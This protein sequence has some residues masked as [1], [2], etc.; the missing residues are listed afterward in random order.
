[1]DHLDDFWHV[2]SPILWPEPPKYFSYSGLNEI[3]TCPR[4]WALSNATYGT[5]GTR[6]LYP[7]K[8]GLSALA[9]QVIHATLDDLV[10]A[11][12]A[13]GCQTAEDAVDVLRSQGGISSAIEQH[14]L[15]VVLSLEANPRMRPRAQELARA[16][17]RQTPE[18]REV[19]QG[20][21]GQV[22]FAQPTRLVA[23]GGGA[24]GTRGVLGHGLH[25]EVK[26]APAR[27]EW[28]GWADAIRLT[29]HECEIIDYKSGAPS[30]SHTEQLRIY[31]LLWARDETLNPAGRLADRL[32]LVYPGSVETS[33]GPSELELQEIERGLR[34]RAQVCSDDLR[35]SPPAARV[36]PNACRYCDVKQLCNAY[37]TDEGQRA[38]C[39]LPP[40]PERSVQ[41]VVTNCR[42]DRVWD[43][44]IEADAYLP[45]GTAAV[46][47]AGDGIT[48]P[49]GG[50]VRLIDIRVSENEAGP[51]LIAIGPRSEIFVLDGQGRP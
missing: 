43:L 11:V 9:G 39:E 21:L 48:L 7:K 22:L 41:V 1:M 46:G 20:A 19:V 29:L 28:I 33:P 27:L 23:G 31:A 16:L 17:Q 14:A 40:P 12:G 3:E 10:T 34:A 2:V 4:R 13:A 6:Y 47:T 45:A 50:R 37:W 35:G 51:P 32:T 42:A 38:I 44:M 36:S 30:S 15:S 24:T 49:I 26:L 8:P 25:T 5:S 18:M